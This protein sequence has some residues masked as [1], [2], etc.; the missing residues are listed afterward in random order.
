MSVSTPYISTEKNGDIYILGEPEGLVAF[1]ELLIL[2]AMLGK[3]LSATFDD[4]VN[5]KIKI[6]S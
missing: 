6:E 1:G 5:P 4:G 2:K 3:S